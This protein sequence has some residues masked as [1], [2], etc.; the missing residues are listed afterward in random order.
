VVAIKEGKEMKSSCSF[1]FPQR[2]DLYISGPN[3]SEAVLVVC[4][5]MSKKVKSSSGK[6][7]VASTA[8]FVSFSDVASVLH[9]NAPCPR[10]KE[11]LCDNSGLQPIYTGQDTELSAVSKKLTK[12]DSV[13]KQTFYIYICMLK[14]LAFYSEETH[15][16]H[17]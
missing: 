9:S 14:F 17:S 15:I 1:L 16:I 11:S 3:I 5:F 6:G 13:T 7:G 2:L 8:N 10:N 4:L 12:K